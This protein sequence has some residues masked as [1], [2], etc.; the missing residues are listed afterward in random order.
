[1]LIFGVLAAMMYI[2]AWENAL[3]TSLQ[4]KPLIVP[5]IVACAAGIGAV[6]QV[7]G[8][9]KGLNEQADKADPVKQKQKAAA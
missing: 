8:G 3:A 5:L 2:D 6:I 4:N 7:G 1:L 9:L